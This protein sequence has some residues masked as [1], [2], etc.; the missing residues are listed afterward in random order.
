MH[1][2]SLQDKVQQVI[3]GKGSLGQIDQ[4]KL[5]IHDVLESLGKPPSLHEVT[6]HNVFDDKWRVNVWIKEY[7]HEDSIA[8]TYSIAHTYFCTLQ[9]NWV[10]DS[11][12]EI[13][14]LY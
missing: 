13:E 12:P 6:A 3:E 8:P 4:E 1:Q 9:D 5:V 14:K 11:N 2:N 10:V 7:K